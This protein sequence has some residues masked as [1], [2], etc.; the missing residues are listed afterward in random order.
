M[1]RK[2]IAAMHL[3]VWLI[4]FFIAIISY[5][6]KKGNLWGYT[7]E[8][9]ASYLISAGLFYSVVYFAL[10]KY[11]PVGKY[12]I[13]ILSIGTILMLSIAVRF[14]FTY[15]IS[16]VIFQI[17]ASSS[18]L[19]K[20][21]QFLTYLLQGTTYLIAACLYWYKTSKEELQKQLAFQIRE[22]AKR[23]KLEL[24]NAVLRAQI[25]PHFT[26]NSLDIFRTATLKT[27]PDVS[28]G[29][30][31]FMKI[32]RSGITSPAEDGKI[33][34][35]IELE[36]IEGTIY[37]FKSRFPDLQLEENLVVE[38]KNN[39]RIVPHIVLPFVENAFKHGLYNDEKNKVIINLFANPS[40]LTL[41]VKN[42]KDTTRIRDKS[43]GIG[44]KYV[45]RHLEYGYK[46]KYNLTINQT[47][48]Y[49]SVDLSVQL[50]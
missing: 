31:W 44:L 26:I 22:N 8:I 6:Y 2:K 16:P 4:Y 18:F 45:K 40:Q 9:F 13:S 37:T 29:I 24:E 43:T 21:E 25:N 36:A 14:L 3:L 17:K 32:L 35:S 5:S 15:F 49:F 20:D 34:F 7:Y 19:G 39:I 30:F 42:K 23:E 50:N 38:D 27:D 1:E 11:W 33:Q 10:Q 28:D 46:G 41:F 48:E 12:F 47:E